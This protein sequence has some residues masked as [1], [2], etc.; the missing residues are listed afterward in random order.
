MPNWN[1]GALKWGSR[2]VKFYSPSSTDASGTVWGTLKGIYILETNTVTRPQ[3]V[4]QQYDEVRTPNGAIGL[5][6]FVTASA[7]VQFGAGQVFIA[8]GDAFSTV[9]DNSPGATAEGFVVT[10]AEEPEAQGDIRKQSIR[11][12]KI[13]TATKPT[14]YP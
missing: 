9:L 2:K 8:T 7:T 4:V 10:N 3:S 12:E 5:D 1:D 6:D 11:L 13:Y 14:T